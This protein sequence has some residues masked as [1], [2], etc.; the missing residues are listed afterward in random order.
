V[1]VPAE[2]NNGAAKFDAATYSAYL[3][4]SGRRPR[5]SPSRRLS[6][7]NS[8]GS[9]TSRRFNEA[10]STSYGLRTDEVPE[11]VQISPRLG[12]NWGRHRDSRN[13][14]RGR[15][16][17]VFSGSPAWVWLGNA[18]QSSGLTG[19]AGLNCN[20][21]TVSATATVSLKPPAFNQ[22]NIDNPPIA[23]DPNTRTVAGQVQTVPGA[24]AALGGAIN[25]IDP[26]FKFPQFLKTSL[27]YDRRLGQNLIAS[28]EGLYTKT[29]Y[30]GVLHQPRAPRAAGGSGRAW[31]VLYGTFSASGGSPTFVPGGRTQVLNIEN[32]TKGYAYNLTGKLERQ[33][34][35]R[36]AASLA[37]TF[38]RARD[39]ASTANS[40]AGSNF[41]LGR[42]VTDTLTKHTLAPSRF[43]QPHRIVATASYTFPTNT[44]VSFIY[45][46]G[47]GFN[48]DFSYGGTG[49]FGDANADGQRNDL[50]YVPL[51]AFDPTE[52]RFSGNQPRSRRRRPRWRATSS[53]RPA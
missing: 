8:R 38:S 45:T 5:T 21:G 42:S 32:T 29:I 22:A 30:D 33:F 34:A 52:I 16:R 9:T 24:T 25:S 44:D 17:V 4:T 1:G 51:S 2:I 19:Y 31:P 27:G 6:A 36:Y 23:C 41:G 49:S 37:Y 50:V 39:V 13:Q 18:F 48:Y 43:E 10:V 40:T 3:Q 47:S 53:A 28:V 26:D 12:F 11:G 14:L 20:S 46:G 35:N 15:R 7:P